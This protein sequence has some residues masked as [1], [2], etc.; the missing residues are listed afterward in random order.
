M[1]SSLEADILKKIP[2]EV[3]EMYVE[4]TTLGKLAQVIH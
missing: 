2:A 1:D 4:A 3:S